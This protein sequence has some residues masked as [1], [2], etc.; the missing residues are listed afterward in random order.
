MRRASVSFAAN[1]GVGPTPLLNVSR[2]A[3]ISTTKT[4]HQTAKQDELRA[5]L[6]LQGAIMDD[7]EKV[8]L[9]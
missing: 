3:H 8:H 9:P 6:A 1:S 5:L 4:Y 2:H 7:F